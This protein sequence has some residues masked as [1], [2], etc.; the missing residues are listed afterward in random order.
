M[1]VGS[2]ADAVGKTLQWELTDIKREGTMGSF[3]LQASRQNPVN[4]L[5]GE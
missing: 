4:T 3:I 1:F 5:K 2:V